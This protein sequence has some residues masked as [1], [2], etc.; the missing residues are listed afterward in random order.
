MRLRVWPARACADLPAR[1]GMASSLV[2]CGIEAFSSDLLLGLIGWVLPPSRMP[3]AAT[4]AREPDSTW[5]LAQPSPC[6]FGRYPHHAGCLGCPDGHQRTPRAVGRTST[7]E[8]S[9]PGTARLGPG[10]GVPLLVP[11]GTG[12]PPRP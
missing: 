9:G 11:G 6:T 3:A 5:P 10:R 2:R 8:P 4:S 7:H 12:G 1:C